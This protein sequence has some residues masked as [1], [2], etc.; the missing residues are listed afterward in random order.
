MNGQRKAI[1]KRIVAILQAATVEIGIPTAKVFSNKA[2]EAVQADDFPCLVVNSKRENV[3][4]I[5]SESPVRDYQLELPITIDCLVSKATDL[6]DDLDDLIDAI[7]K[8][9]TRHELD[10]FNPVAPAWGDLVYAS[11]DQTLQADGNKVT[12]IG[13]VQFNIIYQ[14]VADVSIP[15]E[16]EGVDIEYR[17]KPDSVGVSTDI[18]IAF[19][20]VDLPE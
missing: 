16:L 19:D 8:V 20:S 10:Q 17:L 3:Q 2:I 15:D 12:G 13:Q 5:L 6:G 1:K 14:A 11:S 4:T 7:I 18:A 9:M